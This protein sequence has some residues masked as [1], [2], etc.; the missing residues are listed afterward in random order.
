MAEG[1]FWVNGVEPGKLAIIPRPRG[2]D[3]LGDEV[4]SWTRY[5]LDVI[6]SLLTP[7][8][9]AEFELEG[10]AAQSRAVGLEFK[11]FP[12]P[13]RGVPESRKDALQ[14]FATLMDRVATGKAVGIHCRQGIGRSALVAAGV[15]ALA[16][17]PP[18][19]ALDRIREARG[20]TV[21][22][23]P[24]QRQWVENL[25]PFE[26]TA[27]RVSEG[28]TAIRTPPTNAPLQRTA[29]GRARRRR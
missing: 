25:V 4:R 1:P 3:W 18:G 13:D 19:A 24:E 5:G 8:E 29:H 10:E 22:E 2:G 6:V 11:A 17:L 20:R 21:P 16:G 26:A 28:S 9:Q 15:L 23:T 7:E 27:G 14:L 12:I